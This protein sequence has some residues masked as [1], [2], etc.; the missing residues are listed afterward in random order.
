MD[1]NLV[2]N[3]TQNETATVS[4]VHYTIPVSNNYIIRSI[5]LYQIAIEGNSGVPE[6]VTVTIKCNE[7]GVV[8]DN[9]TSVENALTGSVPVPLYKYCSFIVVVSNCIGNSEPFT[10]AFSKYI[11]RCYLIHQLLLPL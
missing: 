5:I 11:Y 4:T 8:Y 9:T 10:I 1:T 2:V 7:T 3:Y 6:S